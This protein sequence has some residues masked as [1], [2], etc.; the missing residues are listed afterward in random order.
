[1]IILEDLLQQGNLQA[2][3]AGLAKDFIAQNQLPDFQQIAFCVGS[4]EKSS[5]Q[6]EQQQS[7]QPFLLSQA[8]LPVWIER[9]IK[10]SFIG[11]VGI[12]YVDGIQIEFLE[13]G[14]GSGFYGQLLSKLGETRLHHL[15]FFVEEL[16]PHTDKLE[17]NGY[18]IYVIGKS[19]IGAVEVDFHYMDTFEELGFFI[20]FIC[21]SMDGKGFIPEQSM[22]E[23]MALKQREKARNSRINS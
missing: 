16:K 21:F 15:G 3:V 11:K 14:M 20:E 22:I 1:M 2:A 12:G 18:P 8:V 23:G 10:K 7:T 9:G 19:I 13:T 17:Q 6:I 4:S 5:Q